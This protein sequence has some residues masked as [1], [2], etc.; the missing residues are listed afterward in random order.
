MTHCPKCHKPVLNA[1]QFW[2][3]AQFTI[4]CPWCQAVLTLSVQQ[5]VSA[6]LKIPEQPGGYQQQPEYAAAAHD[7]SGFETP[8]PSSSRNAGSDQDGF[9]VVGYIY[10]QGDKPPG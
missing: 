8:M 6:K 7:D 4:K 9:K 10:P 5:Q 1:G 3:C 2:G